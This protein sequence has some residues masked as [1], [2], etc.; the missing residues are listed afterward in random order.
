M[1]VEDVAT[2]ED[3]HQEIGGVDAL[4]NITSETNTAKQ[5]RQSALADVLFHFANQSPPIA[6][7]DFIAPAELNRVVKFGALARLYRNNMTTGGGEDVHGAK[8]RMFQKM[9]EGALGSLRPTVGA[10]AKAAPMSIA[11]HRR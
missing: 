7:H 9:Y 5:A 6:E 8:A 4:R 11:L 10:S 2:D 3:L 1:D